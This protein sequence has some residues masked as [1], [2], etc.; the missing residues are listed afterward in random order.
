MNRKIYIITLLAQLCLTSYAQTVTYKGL[1]ELIEIATTNNKELQSYHLTSESSKATIKT[2]FDIDKT[3][4]YF[5]SD[6][7]NLAPNDR[8]LKVFGVEQSFLFPTVYGARRSLYKS[9]WKEDVSSFEI[10]KNKLALDVS[11]IYQQIV[12][13]QH[14]EVLYKHL[15]ELYTQFASASKKRYEVGESNYLEK[16][17]SE[18]KSKQIYTTLAQI[19]SQRQSLYNELELLVQGDGEY[20]IEVR[21][22]DMVYME[23]SEMGK[24]LQLDYLNSISKTKSLEIKLN[25]QNW[26]P[27]LSIELF[28]GTSK[29]LGYFQNGFQVGISIPLFFNQNIAK[30]RTLKI[31]QQSWEAVKQN[32][33]LQM[34]SKYTKKRAELYQ[35][36]KAIS[37]YDENGNVLAKEIEKTAQKSYQSGEIDFFQYIQSMENA[38]SIEMDYLDTLLKYNISYLELHY[39]NF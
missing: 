37:Y 6:H 12:Y 24:S 25:D 18:A 31:K 28:S 9:K 2:A 38:T 36:K 32:R 4:F 19:T 17:T 22:L 11:L 8:Q 21:T 10:A 27:D 39:Y 34:E 1:S 33:E 30:R 15:N 26:F 35:Y 16:I 7:N 13:I 3:S 14:K 23:N 20:Q 5:A 29:G